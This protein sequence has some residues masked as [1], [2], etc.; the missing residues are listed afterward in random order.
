MLK[1]ARTAWYCDTVLQ[2]VAGLAADARQLISKARDICARYKWAYGDPI[3]PRLLAERMAHLLHL[4]TLYWHLRPFGAGAIICGYDLET[5]E[6]ELYMAETTGELNVRLFPERLLRLSFVRQSSF[7]LGLQR[8]FGCAIGKGARSAKTEIEKYKFNERTVEDSLGYC[9]KIM[10]TVHD[11]T[12]DKEFELE[13]LYLSQQ[14]GWQAQ[15]V[16]DDKVKQ[17]DDWALAQIEREEQE[18]DDD[19]EDVQM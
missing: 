1:H 16:P 15:R 12:K 8:Y 7:E 4:Y 17:A 9:A 2:A 14:T 3:P 11:K 13:L 18:D 6:H 5:Q 19:D 10:H